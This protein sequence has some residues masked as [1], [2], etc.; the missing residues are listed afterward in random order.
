MHTFDGLIRAIHWLSKRDWGRSL[1]LGIASIVALAA[2]PTA[3]PGSV[4]IANAIL[5][6]PVFR[7]GFYVG[8]IVMPR[9]TIGG[10][11]LF[12]ITADFLMFVGFWFVALRLLRRFSPDKPKEC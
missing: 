4:P 10:H 8:T 3:M 2:V 11:S 7:A 1:L 6:G 12:G 5:E 9:E